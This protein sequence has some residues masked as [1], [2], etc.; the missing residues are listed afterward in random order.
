MM[1]LK[2]RVMTL[3]E[4][5]QRLKQSSDTDLLALAQQL[6]PAMTVYTATVGGVEDRFV[7]I[8]EL[9]SADAA[10]RAR[11]KLIATQNTLEKQLFGESAQTAQLPS[12]AVAISS[13]AATP[14]LASP[15]PSLSAF[16][17]PSDSPSPLRYPLT[18]ASA[19]GSSMATTPALPSPI[20]PPSVAS[21]GGGVARRLNYELPASNVS[22]RP[23]QADMK[24][25]DDKSEAD[26]SLP[27]DASL[28][29][30]VLFP[31]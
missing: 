4:A 12:S 19:S 1:S 31:L 9:H 5:A 6:A 24:A 18:T 22:L 10:K 26:G 3:A 2:K 30:S 17:T 13:T 23:F 14:L 25:R 11:E 7:K 15:M 16:S 28:A 8:L 29:P 20:V 21:V 27:S